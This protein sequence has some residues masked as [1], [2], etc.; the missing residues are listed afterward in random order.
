MQITNRY[1]V[2]V[3]LLERLQDDIKDQIT[4]DLVEENRDEIIDIVSDEIIMP[5]LDNMVIYY[6]DC[7]NIISALGFVS[8]SDDNMLGIEINDVCTAAFV[9]LY[10]DVYESGI[11]YDAVDKVLGIY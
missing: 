10:Q 8:F 7:F 2:R 1:D 5:L 6:H 9:A 11:I 3:E 4:I